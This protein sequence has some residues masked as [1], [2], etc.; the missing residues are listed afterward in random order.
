MRTYTD[1]ARQVGVSV[2]AVSLVMRDPATTR[3]SAAKRQAILQLVEDHGVRRP[4][5]G[6]GQLGFIVQE[7]AAMGDG[8]LGM[9]LMGA[10][11]RARQ[12]NRGMLIEGWRDNLEGLP[13][14]AGLDGLI[15]AMPMTLDE[16][17]P[18][19]ARVPC[20]LLEQHVDGAPCDSLR[21]DDRQGIRLAVTHLLAQGHR[22]LAYVGYV[23]PD[24]PMAQWRWGIQHADRRLAFIEAVREGGGEGSVHLLGTVSP[25]PTAADAVRAW[26]A[27]P[28]PPSAAVCFDDHIAVA[29]AAAARA[30]GLPLAITGFND[31][32][33]A[34][35]ADP[36]LTSIAAD[37]PALGAQAVDLL[38]QRIAGLEAPPR[39][40]FS[41]C[42]LAVRASSAAPEA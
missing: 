7:P 4:A 34:R 26:A 30:I 37:L 12:L 28:R 3:V 16:L 32:A 18:L 21:L 20:L 2:A 33:I 19:A 39:R 25:S 9:L 8:H 22:R 41:D 23:S 11:A 6:P 27:L 14:Q 38:L 42:R 1:V 13:R 29:I 15:L 40:L 10:Q 5:A 35:H 36:P 24:L 17:A 31:L